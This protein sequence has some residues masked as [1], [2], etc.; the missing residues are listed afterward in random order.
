MPFVLLQEECVIRFFD[1]KVRLLGCRISVDHCSVWAKYTLL[2]A[3]NMPICNFHD[4]V[5]CFTG[6]HWFFCIVCQRCTE[7]LGALLHMRAHC[8]RYP[9]DRA[10]RT[11]LEYTTIKSSTI[12][13][14]QPCIRLRFPPVDPG[15]ACTR[16]IRC[17]V[18]WLPTRNLRAGIL[19]G[20]RQGSLFYSKRVL[21][22]NYSCKALQCS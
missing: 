10:Q 5:L 12:F 19:L 21:Q 8:R 13:S 1:R 16:A 20:P 17:A 9:K 2:V 7:V 11:V 4:P 3:A 6:F 18:A 22:D 14:T 15:T